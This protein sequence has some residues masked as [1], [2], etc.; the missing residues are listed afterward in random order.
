VEIRELKKQIIPSESNIHECDHDVNGG[1]LEQYFDNKYDIASG[2]G[3][4]KV[5]LKSG[6]TLGELSLGSADSLR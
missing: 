5:V 4:L 6:D 2:C 1:D 3:D